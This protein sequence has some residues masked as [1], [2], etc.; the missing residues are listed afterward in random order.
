MRLTHVRAPPRL[1]SKASWLSLHALKETYR[2]IT[3][4]KLPTRKIVLT[5]SAWLAFWKRTLDASGCL[6]GLNTPSDLERYCAQGVKMA[7]GN[8]KEEFAYEIGKIL[9]KVS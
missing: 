8:G 3:G 9:N 4:D 1:S 7:Q 2:N 6:N 5:T